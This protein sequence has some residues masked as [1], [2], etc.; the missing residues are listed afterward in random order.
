MVN[1]VGSYGSGA[2]A[3]LHSVFKKADASG[4][5]AVSRE[6][7]MRSF[8]QMMRSGGSDAGAPEDQLMNAVGNGGFNAMNGR[9]GGGSSQALLAMQEDGGPFAQ[10]AA[11]ATSRF[12]G[13]GDGALSADEYAAALTGDGTFTAEE[14]STAFGEMDA[15]GDGS[16]SQSELAAAIAAA[17]PPGP[18]P[19]GMNMGG[20]SMGGMNVSGAGTEDA[21]SVAGS[22][23]SDLFAGLDADGDGSITAE[24]LSALFSSAGANLSDDQLNE[25][26]SG[27]D[28]DGDGSVTQSE[29]SRAAQA[30]A[31]PP[32]PQGPPQ[33][34]PPSQSADGTTG[35][36]SDGTTT[37]ASAT[38]GTAAASGS[39]GDYDEMDV[40]RDGVVS[41]QE[42]MAAAGSVADGRTST[43]ALSSR[44]SASV[45]SYMLQNVN[46][47]AA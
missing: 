31:P 14:A 6:D 39:G 43:S 12:D 32:P 41:H 21:G 29:M 18:P 44:L 37:S 40:N 7:G 22:A 20:M 10:M 17:P 13:D 24:E 33:G 46:E 23:A 47:I 2:A 9:F 1:V 5:S 28:G 16:L 8:E 4:D 15:D 11:D 27:L 30:S 35:G 25:L 42:R 3:Q 38:T 19:G 45:V 34:R 36:A 26:F